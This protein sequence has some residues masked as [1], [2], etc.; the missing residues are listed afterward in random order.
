MVSEVGVALIEVPVNRGFCI[1]HRLIVTVL[2]YGAR[3]TAGNRF[4]HVKE[5][6]SWRKRRCLDDW[7]LTA[8]DKIVF[9]DPLE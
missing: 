8:D 9:I 6:S 4:D 2:N 5:L 7:P 3:H 1:I